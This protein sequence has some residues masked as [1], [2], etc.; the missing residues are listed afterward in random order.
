MENNEM[1]AKKMKENLE[2]MMEWGVEEKNAKYLLLC[3]VFGCCPELASVL[4]KE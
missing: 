4:N 3:G 2:L 1:N